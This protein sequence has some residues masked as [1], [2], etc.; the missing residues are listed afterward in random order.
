M[1]KVKTKINKS[2]KAALVLIATLFIIC[3]D[4]M[5]QGGQNE[6]FATTLSDNDIDTTPISTSEFV[7]VGG[8]WVTPT[9]V[10]GRTV[11]V[12]LP[13]VNMSITNLT[14]VIVTPVIAS[15]TKEWPFEIQT[16]GE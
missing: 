11:N 10:H 2:A 5:I 13:V 1:K 4:L 14:N 16:K 7:M 3:G 12:V 8:D 9:A 15:D 6:V